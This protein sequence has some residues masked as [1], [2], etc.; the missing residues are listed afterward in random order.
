MKHLA[1]LLI[2]TACSHTQHAS[3]GGNVQLFLQEQKRLEVDVPIKVNVVKFLNRGIYAEA[4]KS[5]NGNGACVIN[6]REDKMQYLYH[7]M[8]HCMGISH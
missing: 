8:Q 4:R 5:F 2:I 7:E 3:D 1:L 6:I